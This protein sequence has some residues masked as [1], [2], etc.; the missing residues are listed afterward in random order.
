[1]KTIN[2]LLIIIVTS[3]VSGT[4]LIADGLLIAN[5][6]KVPGSLLRNKNT[7]I[8]V[9]ING[10]FSET[11]VRQEFENEWDFEVNGV[12]SFPLPANAR[13]TRLLY[14][15][16]DTMVDAI[17][18]VQQQST[19]PG[20]G[21]GG[22]AANINK[23]MGSNALRIELKRIPAHSRKIVELHY[24][25]ILNQYDGKYFYQYPLNT[26][27]FL[28]VPL[29]YIKINIEVKSSQK[30]TGYEFDF[31][32]GGGISSVSEKDVKLEYFKSKVYAARDILFNYT[33]ENSLFNV[34]LFS[35]KPDTSD[36]YFALVGHPQTEAADTAM[37]SNI[38]F[39]ISNS[40]TMIGSKLDQSKIA[41]SLSLDMLSTK[42]S[43]NIVLYNSRVIKWKSGLVPANPENIAAG[44]EFVSSITG[45]SGSAL[46]EGI[47]QSLEL[48]R[49]SKANS[50]I[51]IFSDGKGLVNP[52]AVQEKNHL[53]IGIFFIAIGN[54]TD[55]SRLE[56]TSAL[57][58]GF[59]TYINEES[60][61]GNEMKQ[62]FRK[63]NRPLLKDIDISYFG[64]DIYELYPSKPSAIYAGTDFIQTGRYSSPGNSNIHFIG[65]G[66]AHSLMLEFQK[67]FSGTATE[68]EF[69]R[70]L[71]AKFAM[72]Q[73]EA[74]ILISGENDS[75]KAVL[76]GM[77]LSNNM[78]CRYTAYTEDTVYIVDPDKIPDGEYTVGIAVNEISDIQSSAILS[79]YP[80]P[81]STSTVLK[82]YISKDDSH[83]SKVF[84]IYDT[85]GRLIRVI[86]ISENS[87]GEH[88][89]TVGSD[90]NKNLING[91]YIIV[92]EI[93]NKPVSTKKIM[94]NN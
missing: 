84:R 64:P 47:I 49:E 59:V 36:G 19:N 44:K 60:I 82:F 62:I 8:T 35:W 53:A 90:I 38:I 41:A 13:T 17:L 10:L 50:S 12:Y 11:I 24:I 69:S 73:I 66:I 67:E 94:V 7:E 32:P 25:S 57:N 65:N 34:D 79:N 83:K 78:R 1:M 33:I 56:T 61:V 68:N 88:K 22:L 70:K 37:S 2:I 27:S 9:S 75:L 72:D 40:S 77:S 15:V 92:L 48:F 28:K 39:L 30:I 80:N 21:T 85:F 20:T 23:Y 16:G 29:D 43:F 63:I 91:I 18:K 89:I 26:G 31:D 42:D 93:D 45:E 52:F 87:E 5:N 76:I 74:Q 71:W 6:P 4:T 3:V 51:L 81:F 46:E 14:S 54:E 58:Y 55:R 86:T